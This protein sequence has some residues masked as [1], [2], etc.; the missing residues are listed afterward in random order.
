MIQ[1]LKTGFKLAQYGA[2][3]KQTM[4]SVVLVF[5]L[6]I[7]FEVMSHGTSYVGCFYILLLSVFPM[8][9]VFSTDVSTMIQ[10]TKM[11]R[12]IQITIPLTMNFILMTIAY[13]VIAVI[14]VVELKMFPEDS[15]IMINNLLLI[16]VTA[17]IFLAYMGACFKYFLVSMIL[18]II[19]F[20]VS[21]LPLFVIFT[22]KE[23]AVFSLPV[24][25]LIG[26]ICILIGLAF[27]Y[28]FLRLFYKKEMSKY[29]FGAQIRKLMQ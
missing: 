5:V 18:F 13:I 28:L 11:K 12:K 4:F 27:Q 17:V 10:T 7:A 20:M 3:F 29:A 2:Q 9:L 8:Q 1:D 21:Y 23:T 16:G 25:L 24:T 6:G 22:V 19:T 26:Y 15:G 14:R